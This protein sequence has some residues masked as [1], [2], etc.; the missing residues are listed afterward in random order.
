MEKIGRS[1]NIASLNIHASSRDFYAVFAELY[2][3]AKESD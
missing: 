1:N 2:A 3:R